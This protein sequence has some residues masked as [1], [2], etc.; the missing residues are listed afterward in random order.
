[1]SG[2]SYVFKYDEYGNTREVYVYG[3]GPAVSGNSFINKGTA[4]THEERECLGL[5]GMLP[6]SVRGLDKQVGQGFLLQ[7]FQYC[8]LAEG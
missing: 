4:F 5:T 3:G 1:M 8:P 2:H 7:L 6:P